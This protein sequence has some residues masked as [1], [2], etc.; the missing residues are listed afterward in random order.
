M[1]RRR[2]SCLTF[3]ERVT[4]EFFSSHDSLVARSVN[5]LLGMQTQLL[6]QLDTGNLGYWDLEGAM[7]GD[8]VTKTV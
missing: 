8:V 3:L 4:I 5:I 2:K 7:E 1:G 6:E